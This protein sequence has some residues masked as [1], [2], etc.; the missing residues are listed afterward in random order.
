[1]IPK[2][3]VAGAKLNPNNLPEIVIDKSEATLVYV[4]AKD[5]YNLP[6]VPMEPLS[7]L[8]LLNTHNAFRKLLG[9][10]ALRW[11]YQ[12]EQSAWNWV[13][14]CVPAHDPNLEYPLGENMASLTS[15]VIKIGDETKN[16]KPGELEMGAG[17][18]WLSEI[19]SYDCK[20]ND[21]RVNPT[22]NK[23]QVCGH[24]VQ[25]AWNGTTHIGC[26]VMNCNSNSP[27]QD[28]VP[29]AKR[30]FWR[31]ISCRY[32]P[33]A[34]VNERP[35]NQRFCGSIDALSKPGKIEG[36]EKIS[37]GFGPL[38]RSPGVGDPN[39]IRSVSTGAARVIPKFGTEVAV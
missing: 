5:T 14:N 31:Q 20:K 36:L 24:F 1:L 27:F 11:S 18:Q 26:A 19:F 8:Q 2:K 23:E 28:F 10:P 35:F 15:D 6:W 16:M 25:A 38:G 22:N 4:V 13:R 12:L 30:D 37:G 21:C 39:S 7:A 33:P 29:Q 34:W 9:I 32:Y 3:P 17:Q